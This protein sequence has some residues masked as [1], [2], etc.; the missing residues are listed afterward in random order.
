MSV[1]SGRRPIDE[2]RTAQRAS[3]VYGE[4][5]PRLDDPAEDY[6]EAS[7]L[8]PSFAPRQTRGHLLEASYELQVSTLRAVKRNRHSPAA[9]LPKPA[10]PP[11]TLPDLL[12]RR[13]STR[14]FGPEGLTLDE[15]SNLLH[16]GY[17]VTTTQSAESTESRGQ[18][19][20]TV[21]SGG[22]LYPLEVYVFAWRVEGLAEGLYHFDPLRRVLETARCKTLK[23]EVASA[24][25]YEEA[26]CGCGA[27]FVISAMFWRTRFKYGLRGYRFALLEAGHVA[28]N[29]QLAA[30][31]LGLGSVPLGGFYDS[32][33][34]ELLGLDG[35]NESTLYCVAVGRAESPL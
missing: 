13:R 4:D 28:Q 10:L 16:A 35:V 15:L 31:A 6:H 22:A 11:V 21:P 20:R 5:G 18:L 8:Y 1:D 29:I 9:K 32:R 3:I 26:A 17:G 23:Q 34:D 27:L 14:V 19:R 7:K 12:S 24:M 25:V 30:E 33:L 2:V